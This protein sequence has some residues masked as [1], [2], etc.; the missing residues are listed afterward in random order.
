MPAR[1]FSGVVN[2]CVAR[3]LQHLAE[4]RKVMNDM[5]ES[6]SSVLLFAD[7]LDDSLRESPKT[8]RVAPN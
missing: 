3:C 5:D 4:L 8:A 7:R 2:N 1:G 6:R